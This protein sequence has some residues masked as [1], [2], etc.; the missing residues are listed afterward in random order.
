MV[1]YLLSL[2][3]LGRIELKMNKILSVSL[4]LAVLQSQH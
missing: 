3:I 1:V 2:A 4:V